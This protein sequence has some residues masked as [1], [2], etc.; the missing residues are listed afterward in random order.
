MNIDRKTI[1]RFRAKHT[2]G[3]GCWEWTASLSSESGY[4]QF[5]AGSMCRAHRVS[6]TIVFG[7]IPPGAQVLHRCDNRKCVKPIHL[8]LGTHLDN[9]ADRNR[10]GRQAKQ[11]GEK[12][13]GAR[14][15]SG[16]VTIIRVL[17]RTGK[18]LQRDLARVFRV[19]VPHISDIVNDKSWKCLRR[20][21][22]GD[23][24]HVSLADY[25]EALRKVRP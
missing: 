16:E 8:F 10:K 2:R 12:H 20:L 24:F 22:A 6:W 5:R 7:D 19:S 25:Q 18:Y 23:D 1:K 13:G 3:P 14:L 9:M 17:Y 15:T 4:G 21:R 11:K